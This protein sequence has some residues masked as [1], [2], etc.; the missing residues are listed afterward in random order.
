MAAVPSLVLGLLGIVP[1][2]IVWIGGLIYAGTIWHRQRPVALLLASGSLLA[3]VTQIT[4]RI[5]IGA[6]PLLYSGPRRNI[7]LITGLI[8]A[9]GLVTSLLLAIAWDLLLAAVIRAVAARPAPPQE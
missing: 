2:L 9:V 3:I 4:N 7:A 6:L 1:F 8:T 5:A